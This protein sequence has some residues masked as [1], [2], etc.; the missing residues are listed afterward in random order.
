[1]CAH[2]LKSPHSGHLHSLRAQEQ[3]LHYLQAQLDPVPKCQGS[4]GL[5]PVTGCNNASTHL[6]I[7]KPHGSSNTLTLSQKAW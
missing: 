1:M 2:I 3:W 4:M 5:R 7:Q 6:L